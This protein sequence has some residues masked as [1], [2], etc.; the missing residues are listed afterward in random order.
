VVASRHVHDRSAQGKLARRAA[1]KLCRV[2]AQLADIPGTA[3][4][5]AF[6]TE[7]YETRLQRAG[8]TVE[9]PEDVARLL[10]ADGQAAPVVIAGLLHDVLEDT[11]TTAQA[12]QDAFGPDVTHLVKALT[13]DP[14]IHGY[15]MRKAA[16]REQ[17]LSA[18][19]DA[20]TVALADKAS[21]LGQAQSPPAPRKLDHYRETLRGIEER[22]G[23]SPLSEL[24]R[25][26]LG[27]L[28][29]A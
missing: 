29:D 12:V 5:I 20:A 21:K 7:A 25:E 27:R 3:A 6:L 9:H 19:R 17:I 11:D 13:Q 1:H 24:L 18:G 26:R 14:A 10:A 22:Y 28:G 8:R 2:S 23:R 15:R 4:A 16:L